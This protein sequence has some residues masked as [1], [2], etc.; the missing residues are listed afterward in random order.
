[1]EW[2]LRL[3]VGFFVG[4]HQAEYDPFHRIQWFVL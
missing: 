1:M 3:A 4:Q 2:R